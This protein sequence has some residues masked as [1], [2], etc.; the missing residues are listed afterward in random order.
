MMEV[1]SREHLERLSEEWKTKDWFMTFL[2]LEDYMEA[3]ARAYQDYADRENW[4]KKNAFQYQQR[5]IFLIR[6]N[7]HGI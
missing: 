6:Q 1:G 3:K 7:H 5:R 2:D 4:A